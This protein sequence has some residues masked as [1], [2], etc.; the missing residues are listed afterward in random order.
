LAV[1]LAAGVLGGCASTTKSADRR[2]VS[3][4]RTGVARVE[5]L[6]ELGTPVSTTKS[7]DGNQV[8]IFTFVQGMNPAGQVPQ[9]IDPEEADAQMMKIMLKQRGISPEAMFD[10]KTLTVQVNYDQDDRVAD[11]FLLDMKK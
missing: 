4:I 3:V 8:D 7:K 9:P 5:I 11:T 1:V 2:D 6:K 10:G